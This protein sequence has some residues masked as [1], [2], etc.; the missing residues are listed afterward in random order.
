MVVF[1]YPGIWWWLELRQTVPDT[2][3]TSVSTPWWRSRKESEVFGWSRSRIFLSDSGCPIGLFFTSHSKI[4]NSSWNGTISFETFV[5]TDFLLCTTIS[6]D[7]NSQTSFRLCYEVGNFGKS[8]S[9]IL[10]PTPQPWSTRILQMF[11][12]SA[13]S[14]H[15]SLGWTKQFTGVLVQSQNMKLRLLVPNA[16][17]SGSPK[18]VQSVLNHDQGGEGHADISFSVE[19]DRTSQWGWVRVTSNLSCLWCNK[20]Y[21]PVQRRLPNLTCCWNPVWYSLDYDLLHAGRNIETAFFAGIEAT[22]VVLFLVILRC[23][24]RKSTVH[25]RTGHVHNFQRLLKCLV[26]FVIFMSICLGVCL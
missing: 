4:G 15:Q 13:L 24:N 19:K 5:E 14:Q 20:N 22:R 6:I 16:A 23:C 9:D 18:D 8:K 12:N 3:N 17:A 21:F 10:P 26:L 11:F 1:L 2:W 7:F 25:N